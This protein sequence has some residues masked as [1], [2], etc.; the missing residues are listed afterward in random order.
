MESILV[1]NS[2]NSS[3][4]SGKNIPRAT[5]QHREITVQAKG[6]KQ[7]KGEGGKYIT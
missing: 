2:Y 5:E 3:S 6:E 1:H 7:A 4:T